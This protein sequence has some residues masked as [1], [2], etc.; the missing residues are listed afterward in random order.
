MKALRLA[1]AA[2]LAATL[3]LAAGAAGD[4]PRKTLAAFAGEAELNAWLEEHR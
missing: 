4:A 2:A 1:L 3:P